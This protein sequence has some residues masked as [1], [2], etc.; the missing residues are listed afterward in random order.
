MSRQRRRRCASRLP[1]YV[2]AALLTLALVLA[3]ALRREGLPRQDLPAERPSPRS[4]PPEAA[5]LLGPP[6]SGADLL[7]GLLELAGVPL[8]SEE[9]AVASHERVTDDRVARGLYESAEVRQVNDALL[10]ALNHSWISLCDF[11]SISALDPIPANLPRDV[12]AAARAFVADA[13]ERAQAARSPLWA[14][15]EPRLS[16]TL[17]YWQQLLRPATLHCVLMHRAPLEVAELLHRHNDVTIDA[18]IAIWEAYYTS[19]LNACRGKAVHVVS[20][21]RLLKH[22]VSEAQTLVTALR[23]SHELLTRLSLNSTLLETFA[24]AHAAAEA[25]EGAP[26]HSD[27]DAERA[28]HRPAQWHKRKSDA[29]QISAWP[30]AALLHDL[31]DAHSSHDAARQLGVH[32]HSSGART[33]RGLEVSRQARN[34]LCRIVPTMERSMPR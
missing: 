33:G 22:P 29:E 21:K 1:L 27:A 8:L 34:E 3:L 15:Q 32:R 24:R 12:E 17:P 28:R 26:Q 9:R 20:H 19:V 2:V 7:A 25:S 13:M 18:G 16:L 5:F 6:H 4:R 14:V 10:K 23:H 11:D 30:S 31:L